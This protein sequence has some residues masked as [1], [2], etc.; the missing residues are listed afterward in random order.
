M[1]IFST[2]K[3]SELGQ[4]NF[5]IGQMYLEKEDLENALKYFN[6]ALES[7]PENPKSLEA[8]QIIK[9]K[10]KNL[11]KEIDTTKDVVFFT[12]KT[13]TTDQINW[14]FDNHY[15]VYSMGFGKDTWGFCFMKNI[16]ALQ[17]RVY[18]SPQIPA[19][20]IE[21]GWED[22]FS[23]T[24]TGYDEKNWLIV[25]QNIE[26]VGDQQ[27]FYNSD[28][29]EDEIDTLYNKG[30]QITNC[31]Y[32]DA[33]LVVMDE[34]SLFTEQEYTFYE[35]Y[36]DEEIDTIWEEERFIHTLLFDGENWLIIHHLCDSW[37]SQGLIN[38]AKFP[39]RDLEKKFDE[40]GEL[41]TSIKHDGEDWNIVYTSM[42][43]EE[44][45]ETDLD[46]DLEDIPNV[47]IEEAMNELNALTGLAAVK[48][49][50]N[51][52]IALINLN[53]IKAERG[54]STAHM[55]HHLVFTGSPGTGKT[56]VARIIGKIFK[57]IGILQ[58]GHLVE[59]DR[60][61]LVAEFV[62]QTATK[63]QQAIEKAMDGVLF[64]DEAYTLSKD[65]DSDFGQE[66]IDTLLKKMEDHRDKM[67]VIVAGYTDE[68]KNFIQSNPGLKTRFNT[69]IQ[70]EDYK[71]DELQ[72]I[73]K[74]LVFDV[75]HQL[76][77]EAEQFAQVYFEYLYKSKDKFFGNAR[78]VR[79]LFEDVLKIQ[80]S[81]LSKEKDLSDEQLRTIDRID[82]E[83]A[84]KDHYTEQKE[85]TLEDV[86]RELNE[87]VGL[88]NVKQQ[89]AALADFIKIEQMRRQSGL[90]S[91]NLA[92]HSVFYGPPGTGKTT[93]ARLMGKIYK[94]LGLMSKGQVIESSRPD[95]VGE[96]IGQTAIKTNKLID[97]AMHGIL[98]VDEAYALSDN[99]GG[100]D[101]G[102]EA[103][104]TLLKRM[105]DD[106]DKLC[107]IIAGYTDKMKGFID[108]NP[109]LKSRFTNY[110]FFENYTADELLKII[111]NQFKA[112][113]YV[114]Q[115]EVDSMLYLIFE[116]WVETADAN[117]GNAR[118]ARNLFEKIKLNQSKRLTKIMNPTR[119]DL[120]SI[121]KEDITTLE[122]FQKIF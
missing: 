61:G 102:K 107:V 44:E 111:Q 19:K 35:A 51:N 122:E 119:L 55:S 1:G 114:A 30:Y 6:K 58:K 23:I 82:L 104:E 33:W 66:A 71:P 116:K 86:M 88:Q 83:T 54:M 73:L 68:M 115:P 84:V 14:Y 56:T 39:F 27:W 94:S 67:V 4:R 18:L 36:P 16:E 34:N 65:S 20:E 2:G 5:D 97:E 26:G 10:I 24:H 117:F 3:L 78:T 89:V 85:Q 31:H 69:Y 48:E 46:I 43:Y 64:I 77:S 40:E 52:L 70:F 109:G 95:L 21:K 57:A 74:K 11:R 63:T 25:M 59:V 105:E 81:R 8:I 118:D 108:T 101:F 80:S 91:K 112:E 113:Q 37:N 45:E 79:N 110:F 13:I 103:I 106:R 28:F 53:K 96:Y 47:S 62:G 93:V 17:Q 12:S 75:E 32:G 90:P 92:L 38:P 7:D 42:I 22:G 72:I 98:F 41:P 87:L 50:I 76:T 49:E 29:P 121:V 99:S 120:T 60:S 9:S 15:V 100:G